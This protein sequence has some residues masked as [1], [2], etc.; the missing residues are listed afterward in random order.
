MRLCGIVV[1]FLPAL[2]FTVCVFIWILPEAILKQGF[3]A[4]SL[5]WGWSQETLGGKRRRETGK[6]RQPINGPLLSKLPL[7]VTGAQS[8]RRTLEN[9]LSCLEG[10]EAGEFTYPPPLSMNSWQAKLALAARE[11]LQPKKWSEK[12]E[13]KWGIDTWDLSGAQGAG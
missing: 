10:K 1:P 12:C 3:G 5:F 2:G 13:G 11:C 9:E 7:Q 4:G 8:C 6:R